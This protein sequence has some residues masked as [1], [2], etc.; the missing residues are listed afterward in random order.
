MSVSFTNSKQSYLQVSGTHLVQ[1]AQSC[2]MHVS[3]KSLQVIFNFKTTKIFFS[4]QWTQRTENMDSVSH[5]FKCI[6]FPHRKEI[7]QRVKVSFCS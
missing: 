3:D 6:I 2:V 4:D 7:P 1:S 5:V